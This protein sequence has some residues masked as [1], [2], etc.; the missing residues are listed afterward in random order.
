MTGRWQSCH[1]VW[2]REFDTWGTHGRKEQTCANRP[3]TSTHKPRHMSTHTYTRISKQI[4]AI[5]KKEGVSTR[6][7]KV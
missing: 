6:R 1:Q 5:L 2:K 7:L 4:G 3:Q